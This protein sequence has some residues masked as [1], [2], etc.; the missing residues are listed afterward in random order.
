MFKRCIR[1]FFALLAN[2]P[3]AIRSRILRLSARSILDKLFN[4]S[5][6]SLINER[7]TKLTHFLNSYAQQ[8]NRNYPNLINYII[9]RWTIEKS[10]REAL[11]IHD[12][13]SNEYQ[14]FT[15]NDIY[16]ASCHVANVLTG[17]KFHL[18]I[19]QTVCYL[20]HSFI[21]QK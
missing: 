13:N 8:K 11:W 7:Q 3:M 1:G 19:H 16:K 20:I 9:H 6:S 4:I 5:H 14:K 17:K 21:I 10:T 18:T 2:V 12:S 15:F